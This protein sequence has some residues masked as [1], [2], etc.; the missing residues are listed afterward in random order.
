MFLLSKT[1]K[2]AIILFA[3]RHLLQKTN[4]NLFKINMRKQRERNIKEK[5]DKL[6][7][8]FDRVLTSAQIAKMRQ[9]V[10]EKKAILRKKRKSIE[11][12]KQ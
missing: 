4:Q 6:S 8:A 2:V 10:T 11:T 9:N 1:K 5:N 3:D 7:I 12:K